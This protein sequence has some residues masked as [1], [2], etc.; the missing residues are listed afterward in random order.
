MVTTTKPYVATNGSVAAP[1]ETT[2]GWVTLAGV[3]FLVGAFASFMWGLAALDAKPFLDETGLLYSTLETW[4]WI[5]LG[6]SAIVAICGIMLLAGVRS[7][8][9]VGIVLAAI[10]SL[11]WLFMLPVFP[12]YAMTVIFIDVLV[13]YGLAVHGLSRE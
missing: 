2:S 4:G 10:S 13:M 5:A 6:W 1:T 3:V 9:A 8:P 11:F 12:L 7:A